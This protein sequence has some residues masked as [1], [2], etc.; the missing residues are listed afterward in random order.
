MLTAW[1]AQA[2]FSDEQTTSFQRFLA[3]IFKVEVGSALAILRILQ[4]ALTTSS[5][6]ALFKA[7]ELVQWALVG[8]EK[9]VDALRLLGVSPSTGLLGT[10]G[11]V[12]NGRSRVGDKLWAGGKYVCDF[13]VI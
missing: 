2:I 12:L 4:G 10:M 6:I 13:L 9:G 5:T 8:Q 11:V 1:Y 3:R 7:F